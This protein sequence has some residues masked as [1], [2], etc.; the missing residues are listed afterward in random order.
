MPFVIPPFVQYQAPLF[1]LRAL[2]DNPPAEGPMFVS[3][4]VDWGVTTPAAAPAVQVAL[5]GNSPVAFSQIVALAVDNARCGADVQFVFTDSGFVLVVPAYTQG[6][7]PVF[8][9][10]LM[11][12]VVGGANV[13]V[14]DMT[15]CQV[16]NTMPPPVSIL[17]SQEQSQASTGGIDLGI[18]A[19]TQIVPASITGTIQTLAITVDEFNSTAGP[20]VADVSLVD[21][22]GRTLWTTVITINPSAQQTV[23]ITIPGLRLR[24]VNGIRAIVSGTTIPTGETGMVINVFY[25]VP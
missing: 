12:Y 20:V 9:N 7:F 8:T 22:T 5:S 6:V 10:A 17:P 1:P 16:L 14:G 21:G 2:W 11:F 25:S 18:N 4:E 13:A 3:L 15:V 24:F 23:P 19:T